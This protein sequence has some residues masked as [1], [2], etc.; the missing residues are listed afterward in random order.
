MRT[1]YATTLT[2]GDPQDAKQALKAIGQWVSAWYARERIKVEWPDAFF[3]TFEEIGQVELKVEP[4][5][6]GHKVSLQSLTVSSI[7]GAQ[8]IDLCWE[9]PDVYDRTLG[10]TTRLAAL[11]TPDTLTVSLELAVKGLT[12]QILPASIL[13]GAPRI[14]KDLSRLR[15]VSMGSHEYN[16]AADII[17]AEDMEGLVDLLLDARR[18]F[19]IVVVSRT[20]DTNRPMVDSQQ[21]AERFAG[22]AKVV[23][24]EDRWAG[25]ALTEALSKELSCYAGAVRIYWPRFHIDAD[26]RRHQNWMPWSLREAAGVKQLSDTVMTMA[27][28]AAAFR[29]VEPGEVLALRAAAEK[30][31]RE[32][33]REAASEDVDGWI[34]DIE[35]LEDLLSKANAE[36]GELRSENQTLKDNAAA[37]YQGS[38]AAPQEPATHSAAPA[39]AAEAEPKTV[40]EAL[41]QAIAKTKYLIYL[42][43]ATASATASPFKNPPRVLQTLE[44]IDVVAEQWVASIESGKGI[45]PIRDHFRKLGF[46]YKDGISQTSQGKY[47]DEYKATHNGSTIDISQHITIGAKQID[48]CL[49]IHIAWLKDEKRVVIAHVGRHKTNTK[50]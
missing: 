48:T 4:Q 40:L 6:A 49:S 26:P 38:Y 24:L 41:N 28:D 11:H 35:R 13:L 43:S 21:L 1:V 22:V 27:C 50:T 36:V 44:A 3:K 29:H 39:A 18:P 45:G 47:G 19:P 37:I 25:F 9:N 46:E 20:L 33:R 5:K 14:I 42:P 7:P 2:V 8:L 16:L 23:E 30:E 17:P 10:W 32:A 15:S 12:F 34:D 31:A